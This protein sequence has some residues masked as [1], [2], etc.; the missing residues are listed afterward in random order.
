MFDLASDLALAFLTNYREILG[1][2]QFT[3]FLLLVDILQVKADV[4][5]RSIKQLP[6]LCL[7]QPHGLLVECDLQLCHAIFT[8][9]YLNLRALY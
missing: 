4:A 1:S 8:G 7:T 6:H 9:E 3:Q 2:C 5:D